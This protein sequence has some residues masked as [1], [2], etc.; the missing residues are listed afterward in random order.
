MNSVHLSRVG[1]PFLMQ[2][3]R[4]NC[5][6]FCIF[7]LKKNILLNLL[8]VKVGYMIEVI[9]QNFVK[10]YLIV[11]GIPYVMMMSTYM[12]IR[13]LK[14]CWLWQSSAYLLKL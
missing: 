4:Y 1:E 10:R 13:L 8:P 7:N 2:D 6:V 14:T 5:P 12:Q 11:K 9:T 3:I